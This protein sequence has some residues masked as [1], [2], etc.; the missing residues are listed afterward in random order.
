ML[1]LPPPGDLSGGPRDRAIARTGHRRGRRRG[2]RRAD[3]RRPDDREP[4]LSQGPGSARRR[5]SRGLRP[6]DARGRQAPGRRDDPRGGRVPAEGRPRPR[7]LDH[8]VPPAADGKQP[9]HDDRRGAPRPRL[10][11]PEG[12]VRRRE[13]A[14]S[15]RPRLADKSPSRRHRGPRFP[16]VGTEIRRRLARR[17]PFRR[18]RPAQNP[19]RSI[20]CTNRR[21]G[22]R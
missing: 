12:P 11:R 8:L 3:A 17:D 22:S 4:V 2:R 9:L 10:L 14:D 1:L 6:L 7:P 21:C 20:A 18:R 15:E 5:D 13:E 16:P 19:S